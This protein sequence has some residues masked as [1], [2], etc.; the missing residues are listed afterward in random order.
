[1]GICNVLISYFEFLIVPLFE[2]LHTDVK[3]AVTVTDW[4]WFPWLQHLGLVAMVGS[5]VLMRFV[6]ITISCEVCP[7]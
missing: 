6:A 4:M 3:L 1:M 7:S 2:S 5:C